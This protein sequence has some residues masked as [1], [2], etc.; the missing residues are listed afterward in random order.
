MPIISLPE[1]LATVIGSTTGIGGVAILC[2]L[3]AQR[4]K[5]DAE[6]VKAARDFA[7]SKRAMIHSA[8]DAGRLKADVLDKLAEQLERSTAIAGLPNGLH[9]PS[10]EAGE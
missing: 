1:N 2:R 3:F 9:E 8:F 4:Y 5:A 7:Y 6:R 10:V